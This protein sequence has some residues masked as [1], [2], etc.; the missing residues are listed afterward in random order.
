[1]LSHGFPQQLNKTVGLNPPLAAMVLPAP[2]WWGQTCL[3]S[4]AGG[5]MKE[6]TVM[7]DNVVT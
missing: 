1:M 2:Y 3:V 7:M 6:N 4:L 5:W